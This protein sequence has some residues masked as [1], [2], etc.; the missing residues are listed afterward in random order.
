MIPLRSAF[1]A[2]ALLWAW[3]LSAQE[4]VA[5]VLGNADYAT[6]GALVNPV[7]DASDITSALEGLGFDV[8]LG[9]DLTRAEMIETTER[10]VTMAA[11]A[12]VALFYYAGHGFQVG[13]ENFLVPVD[14]AIARAED[15]PGQTFALQPLL[16]ALDGTDALKLIFLDACRDNPFGAALEADPRL[17]D[18]L[19]RPDVPYTDFF[20]AYATNPNNVAF[21]GT[22]RNSFFTEAMRSHIYTPGQ[23]I[24]ALLLNVRIDVKNATGGR[25]IPFNSS[26]LTRQFQFDPSPPT[27]S[28]ETMLWQV[29]ADV[30]DPLLMQIYLDRY[31]EGR[32]TEEVMGLLDT[33]TELSRSLGNGYDDAQAERLWNLARRTRMRPLLEFYLERYPQGAHVEEAGRLLAVIPRPE[34]ASPGNICE[35]LATHPRD[36]TSTNPGIPFPQLQENAFA[37]IQACGAAVTLTPELPHYTALL[38][39][40]THAAGDLD[41]AVGLYQTAADDGDLRAMV[42]LAQLY[43]AGNGVPQQTDVG[44]ALYERAAE[45]GSADAMINL[46]VTLFQGN[47]VPADPDRA[48]ALLRRAAEDGSGQALYNLGVLAK[49]G[50]IDSPADALEYFLRAGRSGWMDGWRAAAILLDGG[51]GVQADPSAASVMLLRGAAEDSGQTLALME[52]HG[53]QLSRQTIAAT[54]TRLQRAGFYTAA[55]DGLPGPG[56][57]LALQEWR[58]GGFDPEVLV[59]PPEG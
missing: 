23:E 14:A 21:D 42:S 30:R 29:A 51:V 46:A 11:E 48:I 19:A 2:I 28:E 55:I 33:E 10:F 37:A 16:E 18:G 45:G 40:A 25:Q 4:R 31:P 50:V 59:G 58:A 1:L 6:V 20:F 5:L 39:R 22:G 8:L 17:G 34:D 52:T 36:A 35:R 38:A 15:V 32:H 27:V 56:L 7:N 54:Q 26:S 3:P 12:E 53:D 24:S 44:L 47:L 9:T 49:D 57:M 13:G 41:R 43:I